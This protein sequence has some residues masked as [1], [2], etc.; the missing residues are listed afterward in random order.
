VLR[1]CQ[2]S[3][4]D[5]SSRRVGGGFRVTP[6]GGRGRYTTLE[7]KLAR[8]P[9]TSTGCNGGLSRSGAEDRAAL[10]GVAKLILPGSCPDQDTQKP[11]APSSIFHAP[12]YGLPPGCHPYEIIDHHARHRAVQVDTPGARAAFEL[13]EAG[14]R[15]RPPASS[16]KGILPVVG[17]IKNQLG[18]PTFI[19]FGWGPD[20]YNLTVPMK[21][22]PLLLP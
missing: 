11:L 17:L 2:A 6:L 9:A 8:R 1:V 13:S 20:D 10:Q 21:S 16:A 7:R 14:F 3:L 19:A 18:V 4:S 5:A 15:K 22:S 12:E